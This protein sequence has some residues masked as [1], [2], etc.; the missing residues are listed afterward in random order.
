MKIVDKGLPWREWAF[1]LIV[2]KKQ[3]NSG[4]VAVLV[5]ERFIDAALALDE[6]GLIEVKV[7][8]EPTVTT[9]VNPLVLPWH[10]ATMTTLGLEFVE[11]RI[12]QP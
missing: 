1:L 8:E 6:K 4:N 12:D 2:Y 7:I 5:E 3:L 10:Y 11:S 9:G